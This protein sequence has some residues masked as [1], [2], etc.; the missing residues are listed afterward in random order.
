MYFLYLNKIIKNKTTPSEN[1]IT[2]AQIIYYLLHFVIQLPYPYD[3]PS[4][5]VKNP[6]N[7]FFFKTKFL[8]YFKTLDILTMDVNEYKNYCKNNL[9]YV[10]NTWNEKQ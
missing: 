3:K 10:L 8:K 2:K 1:K 6:P 5:I 4:S 7:T 9:N